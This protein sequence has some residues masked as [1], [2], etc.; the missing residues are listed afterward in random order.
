MKKAI[1]YLKVLGIKCDKNGNILSKL[2]DGQKGIALIGMLEDATIE[3]DYCFT[4]I[5][6]K[7]EKIEC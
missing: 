3:N 1:E 4:I 7:I 6:N 2:P 5:N